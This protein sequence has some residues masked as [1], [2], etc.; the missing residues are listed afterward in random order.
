MGGPLLSNEIGSG[1][2]ISSCVG[3]STGTSFETL[4]SSISGLELPV[5]GCF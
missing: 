5:L 2:E 3:T 4:R 1:D